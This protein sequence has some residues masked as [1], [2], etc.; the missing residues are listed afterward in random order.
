MEAKD[1]NKK[2]IELEQIYK[3]IQSANDRGDYK[4]FIPHCVFIDESIKMQ[5]I[6]DGFKVSKGD[7]DG[8]AKDC[9]IIEW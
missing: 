3:D 4:W 6:N 9:I 2:S 8:I 5:L 7:W 1:L